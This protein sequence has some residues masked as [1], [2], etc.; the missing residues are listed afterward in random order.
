MTK[1][2]RREYIFFFKASYA[3]IKTIFPL[4]SFATSANINPFFPLLSLDARVIICRHEP[5]LST[6]YPHYC[7]HPLSE[8]AKSTPVPSTSHAFTCPTIV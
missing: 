5:S 6:L 7:Q 3:N 2:K 8:I 1:W 4:Q